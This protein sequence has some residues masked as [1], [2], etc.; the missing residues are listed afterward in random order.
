M[1]AGRG[2]GQISEEAC[3]DGAVLMEGKEKYLTGK[4]RKTIKK[5]S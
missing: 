5:W 2:A 1:K 4:D 3:S